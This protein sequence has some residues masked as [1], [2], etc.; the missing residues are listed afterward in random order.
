VLHVRRSRVAVAEGSGRP[1]AVV[2][3]KPLV[4]ACGEGALELIEVQSEGRK[5]V[6]AADFANG[7]RLVENEVL[8][9]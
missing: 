3:V 4:V 1:G 7:Q 5:R 9:E 6:A 8:G 2:S